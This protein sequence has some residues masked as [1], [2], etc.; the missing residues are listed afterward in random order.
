[1]STK[2]MVSRRSLLAGVAASAILPWRP[3]RAAPAAAPDW[4]DL[5]KLI[6]SPVFAPLFRLRHADRASDR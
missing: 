6:G 3:S 5:A 2:S 4:G 1:M